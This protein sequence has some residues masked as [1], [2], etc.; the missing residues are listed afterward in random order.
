MSSP[1]S[2][3]PHRD[4]PDSYFSEFSVIPNLTL[5]PDWTS[6]LLPGALT[7]AMFPAPDD[8]QP[9]KVLVCSTSP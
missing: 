6:S 3:G 5:L 7:V 2:T 4:H 1:L 8:I 9:E